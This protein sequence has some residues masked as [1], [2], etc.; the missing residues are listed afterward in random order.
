MKIRFVKGLTTE[1]KPD[2]VLG[3]KLHYEV[4]CNSYT[5]SQYGTLTTDDG[6][7]FYGV[8]DVQEITQEENQADRT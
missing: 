7:F 8:S 1:N 6:R 5:L 3:Y 4:K 2:Y